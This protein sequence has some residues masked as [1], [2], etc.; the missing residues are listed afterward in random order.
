[1]NTEHP[2]FDDAEVRQ[3]VQ[4]AVDVRRVLEAAYFGVG[5]AAR[6]GSSR[7]GLIGHREKLLYDPDPDRGARLLAEA[8]H[9]NGFELH[10]R[11]PQQDRASDRRPGDPG[12]PRRD[13][14]QGRRSTSTI[15]ARSGC[16]ASEA[17]AT[18]GRTSSSSCNRFS[19][20]PDPSFATALVHARADRRLELGALEQP[21]VRRAAP[22]GDGRDRPGRAR[23]TCT[24]ACRT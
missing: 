10:A 22:A 21:G 9:P 13:R 6:P 4:H 12:Q 14:H 18:A 23:P 1:M 8:G 17:E 7:P 11:H 24:A 19:M 3:A 2:P 16:S 20:Q 5:R 15:P